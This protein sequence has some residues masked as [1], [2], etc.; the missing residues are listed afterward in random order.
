MKFRKADDKLA[1]LQGLKARALALGKAPADGTKPPKMVPPK[2]V[3][4][5]RAALGEQAELISNAQH[6]LLE[7]ERQSISMEAL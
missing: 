5:L 2:Q 6:Q 3:R 4:S 1:L 7:L